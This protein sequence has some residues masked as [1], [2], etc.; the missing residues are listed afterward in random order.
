MV[1]RLTSNRS[2]AVERPPHGRFLLATRDQPGLVARVATFFYDR[3]INIVEAASCS[4]PHADSG[5]MFFLR[6]SVDLAEF[7]A[8]TDPAGSRRALEDDFAAMAS[9]LHAIWSVGYADVLARVAI[10]VTREDSCLYD[11]VLRQRQGELPC[12]I[13]LII[14]NHETLEDV[15]E[16]FGIPYHALPV[17][18]AT[19]RDQERKILDLLA[20]HHVDVVVLA[21]YMQVMSEDFL[22][23]APPV[24]NIHHGF[25]PA[26]QGAK[27]YHQAYAR[28]VKLVGATAHYATKD[29]DQGPIIEQDVVRVDHRMGPVDL[30]RLGRDVERVVL[31]RAVRAH[32]ERRIIVEGRRTVVL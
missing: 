21:R 15:A 14:S 8:R 10:L 11:L 3:N 26:F 29:L 28:G 19:R 20:R 13:P 32:L 24:I 31:A 12:D 23:L 6:M 7:H 16:R 5:P 1:S 4:D 9:R 17:V 27:P 2:S 18:D 22:G 30:A 25:L